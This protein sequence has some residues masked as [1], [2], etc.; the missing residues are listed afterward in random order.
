MISDTLVAHRL[1]GQYFV[2]DHQLFV[3][4][5]TLHVNERWLFQLRSFTEIDN[6]AW[7]YHRRLTLVLH[8]VYSRYMD[9]LSG[10][11]WFAVLF[12]FNQGQE[13]EILNQSCN[14][15]LTG[16]GV[17]KQTSWALNHGAG[18]ILGLV[19]L[20]ETDQ[21]P[22]AKGVATGKHARDAVLTM[23]LV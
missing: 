21:T 4:T 15:T 3:L 2:P 22:G 23:P 1:T 13:R 17:P 20:R 6:L 7:L 14:R 8:R 12:A 10:L 16:K 19:P 5:T 11:G 9:W 18:S